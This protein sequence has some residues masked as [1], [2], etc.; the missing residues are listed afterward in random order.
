MANLPFGWRLF[1]WHAERCEGKRV[2]F[3]ETAA[4]HTVSAYEVMIAWASDYSMD[5][6]VRGDVA[7]VMDLVDEVMPMEYHRA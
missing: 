7:A 1:L 4:M 3:D 6:Q 2:V 5:G